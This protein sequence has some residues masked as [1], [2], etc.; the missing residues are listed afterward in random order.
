MVHSAPGSCTCPRASR[1]DL[2]AAAHPAPALSAL[3]N[4]F[5]IVARGAHS[6]GPPPWNDTT[7][8]HS[9]YTMRPPPA[10]RKARKLRSRTRPPAA[11]AACGAA[12]PW[13]N[14]ATLR[15]VPSVAAAGPG[16]GHPQLGR[17]RGRPITV[18]RSAKSDRQFQDMAL[19]DAAAS[20]PMLSDDTGTAL[21]PGEACEGL[22][23]QAQEGRVRDAGASLVP[24]D[25]PAAGSARWCSGAKQPSK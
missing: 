5:R 24:I 19:S 13:Q 18:C 15:R 20:G 1:L 11:L 21:K 7:S 6:S 9:A 2:S 12:G 16:E 4:R 22:L 17:E 25:Q 23:S 10:A 8:S 3:T 14:S